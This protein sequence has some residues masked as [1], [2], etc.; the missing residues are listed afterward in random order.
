M[1]KRKRDNKEEKDLI[2]YKKKRINLA[3]V[4]WRNLAK[5]TG[6]YLQNS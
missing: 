2:N 4:E 6:K 5:I 1:L 3:G